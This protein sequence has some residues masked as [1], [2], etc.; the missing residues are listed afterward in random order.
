MSAT[1]MPSDVDEAYRAVIGHQG[2]AHYL[3]R[4]QRFDAGQGRASWHWPAFFVTGFWLLYRKM[5]LYWL[6]YVGLSWL[7]MFLLGAIGAA[8]EGGKTFAGGLFLLY[9][10]ALFTLVPMYANALYHRHCRRKMAGVAMHD[11][12]AQRQLGELAAVGGTS[13]LALA[14][15]LVLSAV[16][17]VGVLAAV[18]LPAY[19][20]YTVKARVAQAL[21]YADGAADAVGRH[22]GAHQQVPASLQAADFTAPPPAGVQAI[23]VNPNNGF[24]TVTLDFAPLAGKALLLVPSKGRDQQIAWACTS[25]EVAPRYLPPRCRPAA[26]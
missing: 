5:W 18:A 22:Y 19:Q 21:V 7:L 23:T 20:D 17:G 12:P 15:V 16:P 10:L 13:L 14:I 26:R 24:V 6:G 1:M 9:L 2:Q 8:G 11:A 25:T 3:R 4:F